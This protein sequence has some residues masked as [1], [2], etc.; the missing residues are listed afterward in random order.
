ML[1]PY[2]AFSEFSASY[3]DEQPGYI[4]LLIHSTSD[5]YDCC[6]MTLTYTFHEIV[7]MQ[8]VSPANN[9]ICFK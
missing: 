1:L 7:I 2:H 9:L 4:R 8:S 3:P 5:E 6:A